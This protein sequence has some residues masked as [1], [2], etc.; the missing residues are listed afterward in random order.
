MLFQT[1]QEYFVVVVD[2]NIA[3]FLMA[4]S[5]LDIEDMVC[6]YVRFVRSDFFKL[7]LSP[8]LSSFTRR[9]RRRTGNVGIE[10]Q[11]FDLFLTKGK[12]KGKFCSSKNAL[13]ILT[14]S[15][16]P[17]THFLLGMV[18]FSDK[19]R[20]QWGVKQTTRTLQKN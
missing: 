12:R 18:Q 16:V 15:A 17:H 19:I 1:R 6:V 14:A 3:I 5:Y 2:T 11:L 8:A 9:R 20:Q 4:S 13:S 10:T 7:D